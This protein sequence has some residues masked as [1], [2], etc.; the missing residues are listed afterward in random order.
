VF[1][2][3]ISKKI[4]I[5]TR[6]RERKAIAGYK[7]GHRIHTDSSAEGKLYSAVQWENLNILIISFKMKKNKASAYCV[8]V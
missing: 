7:E 1:S 5:N 4:L 2:I 3:Y 6:G 8:I